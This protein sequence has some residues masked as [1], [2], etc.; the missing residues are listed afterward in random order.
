M[1][2]ITE[3]AEAV[4][5]LVETQLDEIM[6]LSEIERTTK[7][8]MQKIGAE[9]SKIVITRRQPQY[10]EPYMACACGAKANYIRDRTVN[11][12]TILGKI[13][14][15]R[16]YYLCPTCHKGVCPLDEQLGLRPNALSCELERLVALTGVQIPFG[17][18]SMLFEE[19]TL[20]TVSDQTMGKASR[21][22]GECVVKQEE[23][24]KQQAND[25]TY[26]QQQKQEGAAPLRLYGAI[27]AVKVNIRGEKEAGWR[28]LK[29]GA[30][31]EACGKPPTSPEG[32]WS[33]QAENID[34]FADLCPANEF[35]PLVWATAVQR[36][37]Q[38]ARELILLGDGA[39][40][41][42]NIVSENFPQAIQILDWF[43]ASEHLMPVAQAAFVDEGQ[44]SQWVAQQRKQMWE[45]KIEAVIATCRT[46]AE[47][48]ASAV[49]DKAAN[50]F[51]THKTRM[52]YAYFRSQGYQIGSGT[53]ES[54]AKQIGMMRM[55]V[56]GAR[57]N[58][59]NAILVAKARAAF[60]SNRWDDLPL[61][62]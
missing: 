18:G 22:M 1:K 34:Y 27:D 3:I 42:W 4:A 2:N 20:I 15:E 50:Y 9:V 29:L 14:V 16:A 45:G 59:E 32:Q 6:T 24:L 33:I 17:K 41:I 31:F 5:T 40:W 23:Q 35:S 58:E 62:V 39:E 57:W 60:L 10:P 56:P 13:E 30:W 36:K 55:K 54:A 7:H 53:I 11:L 49:I 28:D 26:L 51:E 61:A 44:R 19:L 46:L 21:H 8:L 43:H 12:Y 25:P 38:L 48:H 47:T 37:A 52:R